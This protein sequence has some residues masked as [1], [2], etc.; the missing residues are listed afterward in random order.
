[1]GKDKA[2]AFNTNVHHYKKIIYLMK[3]YIIKSKEAE[4][5]GDQPEVCLMV[6]HQTLLQELIQSRKLSFNFHKSTNSIARGIQNNLVK[7][8]KDSFDLKTNQISIS[9]ILCVE[10]KD[11]GVQN[12]TI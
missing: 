4:I 7:V 6:Q 8:F 10:N 9:H 2:E 12:E 1:M 11:S 5:T 3:F